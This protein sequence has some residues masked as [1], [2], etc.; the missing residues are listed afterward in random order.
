M[1]LAQPLCAEAGNN[2]GRS[3]RTHGPVGILDPIVKLHLLAAVKGWRRI[4]ND[5][6]IQ[7]GRNLVAL[8]PCR[9]SRALDCIGPRHDRGQV[10][11]VQRFRSARDLDEKIGPPDDILQRCRP[12]AGEYLAN[13]LGQEGH[14]IDDMVREAGKAG[15]QIVVLRTHTDRAGV[16]MALAHHQTAQRDQRSRTDAEFLG[17]QHGCHDDIAARADAAIGA[18][19]DAF[20]QPVQRQHLVCFG[21]AQFQRTAGELDRGQRRGTGATDRAGDVDNVGIGLGN[22]GSNSTNTGRSHQFHANPGLRIDLLEIIDQLSQVFDRIDVMVGRW[23]D[24]ADPWGRVPHAGN[25][26]GDLETGQ[27]PPLA[28]FGA[29]G[30]LD[31][32]LPALVQILGRD[33]EAA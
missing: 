22:A 7:A 11:I 16:G 26:F 27:L 14:Q 32:E 25:E 29:L 12:Q 6:F 8:G 15:A 17:A 31:L 24:E 33:T 4:G 30:N 20:A 9:P 18:Q 10:E 3:P 28:G 1:V 19:G 21:Q 13:I 2:F 23:R 5:L